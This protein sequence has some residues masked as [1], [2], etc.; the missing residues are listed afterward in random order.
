MRTGIEIKQ[1][2]NDALQKLAAEIDATHKKDG[3]IDSSELSIFT[4]QA[5]ELEKGSFTDEDFAQV[6]G[7]FR[8]G[9]SAKKERASLSWGEIGKT[10]LKSVGNFFKGMLC[11]ENGFSIKRTGTTLGTVAVLAGAAPLAAALGAGAGVVGGIAIGTKIIGTVFAGY[12][13]I[14]GGSKVVK[15]TT[16]YYDA[17]TQEEAQQAMNEAMDGGIETVFALP[18]L[19]GVFKANNKGVQLSK[20]N[21]K[22][23]TTEPKVELKHIKDGIYKKTEFNMEG[24]PIKSRI[25][26]KN[27]KLSCETI[28]EYAE[29]GSWKK[30]TSYTTKEN[31]VKITL[32]RKGSFSHSIE[33]RVKPDGSKLVIEENGVYSKHVMEYDAQGNLKLEYE[34]KYDGASQ[35]SSTTTETIIQNGKKITTV[36][37]TARKGSN[38]GKIIGYKKYVDGILKSDRTFEYTENKVIETRHYSGGSKKKITLDGEY[39]A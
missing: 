23:K 16:K 13:A 34:F 27:N 11:D 33:T 10:G 17:K 24:K 5:N 9:S 7:L 37:E 25:F 3:Y 26:D 31:G 35:G 20:K 4:I 28:Y 32:E 30:Q 1:I 36:T 18:A 6:M 29:G 21:A 12:M 39:F 8:G 14:D 15:G 19:L 22:V 38:L 2:S